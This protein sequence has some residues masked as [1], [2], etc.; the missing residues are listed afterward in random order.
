MYDDE[1]N[2]I[3]LLSQE[4]KKEIAETTQLHITDI[5]DVISKYK[6]MKGF[7]EWLKDKKAHNEPIP[8][9]REELMQM[10]RIERPKFLM[11]SRQKQS[12]KKGDMKIAVRRH[13]T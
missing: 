5:Q 4:V 8:E 7:H 10:Y 12:P 9:S 6:Q 13:H 3:T 2:D 11:E 1:K